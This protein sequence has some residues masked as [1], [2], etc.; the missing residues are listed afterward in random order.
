MSSWEG[1]DLIS[2]KGVE[3]IYQ[4]GFPPKG[5]LS[6]PTDPR[7][8]YA[9]VVEDI[10]EGAEGVYAYFPTERLARDF[11]RT[12]RSAN[13]SSKNGR[14]GRKPISKPYK[15]KTS[16][17]RKEIDDGKFWVK[18]TKKRVKNGRKWVNDY[19]VDVIKDYKELKK[20][21][22]SENKE[23]TNLDNIVYGELIDK[24][25]GSNPF[26]KAKFKKTSADTRVDS[27]GFPLNTARVSEKYTSNP[28]HF[29]SIN[30]AH[31]LIP[32]PRYNG[33]K[34]D[35][36]PFIHYNVGFSNDEVKV[37]TAFDYNDEHI[38]SFEESLAE[39]N[40][41]AGELFTNGSSEIKDEFGQNTGQRLVFTIP[42]LFNG[43][44]SKMADNLDRRGEGEQ[45]LDLIDPESKGDYSNRGSTASP[46]KRY[47]D[48][49][50]DIVGSG[51]YIERTP[52]F[53][54]ENGLY[55]VEKQYGKNKEVVQL[56]LIQRLGGVGGRSYPRLRIKSIENP[57]S[58]FVDLGY[59][60]FRL[61]DLGELTDIAFAKRA[62]PDATENWSYDNSFPN[63]EVHITRRYGLNT[64]TNTKNINTS[65]PNDM[66][67]IPDIRDWAISKGNQGWLNR[68]ILPFDRQKYKLRYLAEV[69]ALNRRNHYVRKIGDDYYSNTAGKHIW[70][71]KK[72]AKNAAKWNRR[73]NV[74]TR[75]IKVRNGYANIAKIPTEV[76]QA[77]KNNRRATE[78]VVRNGKDKGKIRN[79][80][81]DYLKG[82]PKSQ[83]AEEIG[84]GSDATKKY[85]KRY[86]ENLGTI[87][88]ST[89]TYLKQKYP[90][91]QTTTKNILRGD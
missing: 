52:E 51:W 10:S 90:S 89:R 45:V 42:Q 73:N 82:T 36:G 48:Y 3:P 28:I 67:V 44:W 63:R 6:H 68:E 88:N 8:T 32:R 56:H 65:F 15:L 17:T 85:I 86:K 27:D 29:D 12:L 24:K 91:W 54:K 25:Y 4:D 64:I 9:W 69:D 40:I 83:M 75:T 19:Q 59:G 81:T 55:E 1:S 71:S 14:R 70:E 77:I 18:I 60:E 37:F 5:Y 35:G 47:G 43:E 72:D 31:E 62:N 80:I 33:F 50:E 78:Y 39:G 41:S 20:T 21:V 13:Q 26:Y 57:P 87:K 84:T 66:G 79:S 34:E 76:I 49:I 11:E 22:E 38:D 61:P 74:N 53:A 2:K 46:N 30:G 23:I 7:P 58:N 16:I